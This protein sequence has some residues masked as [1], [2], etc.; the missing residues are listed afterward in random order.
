MLYGF[1]CDVRHLE[2]ASLVSKRVQYKHD[3]SRT[4]VSSDSTSCVIIMVIMHCHHD[5]HDVVVADLMVTHVVFLILSPH[6]R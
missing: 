2:L 1:L 4:H 5:G 6:V 3:G